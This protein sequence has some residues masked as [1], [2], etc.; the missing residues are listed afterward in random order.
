MVFRVSGV[1]ASF[2]LPLD[3]AV[4]WMVPT[5]VAASTCVHVC[6]VGGGGSS[7]VSP[8]AG[9]VVVVVVASPFSTS[10]SSRCLANSARI[11]S[12]CSSPCRFN[13]AM[14]FLT[15]KEHGFVLKRFPLL[16]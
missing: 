9:V 10:S 15:A 11:I 8:S 16:S 14:Y 2:S 1:V 4:S 6:A 13:L 7:F 3:V 12:R 5:C